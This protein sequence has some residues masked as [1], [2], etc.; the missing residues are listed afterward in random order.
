M[1]T[2]KQ[3]IF[4]ELPSNIKSEI[5]LEMYSGVIK[6]IRFF[7][8]K[9]NNFIGSIVPLLTFSKASRYELI[10]KKDSHPHAIYFITNGRVSFYLERKDI[11]F[12]DM[13]EGGYFGDLDIIFKRK[14]RYTMISTS[15]SDFLIMT[16]QIFEE[17]VIKEY[18]EVY[19][20]MTLVAFE[21]EKRIQSAMQIALIEYHQVMEK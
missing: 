20:E 3:K 21:R 4:E 12:K 2:D 11:A 6:K 7:D 9:D 15:E 13:I 16:K 14:R 18:P 1:W 17:I 5:A 10:Y 19:E 8:D